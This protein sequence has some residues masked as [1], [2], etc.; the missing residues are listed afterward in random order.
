[1]AKLNQVV[2][3]EK[4][5]KSRVYSEITEI[6][7]AAQKPVLFNGFV[8]TYERKDEDSETYPQEQQ[9]VQMLAGDSLSRV[10]TL[11]TEMFDVTATKDYGN[12][13]AVADIA[14]DGQVLVNAVPVPFLLFLEKQLNDIRT[15]VENLPVLDEADEWS[16]DDATGLFKTKPVATH[17]TKKVQKPIVLYNATP[18][19]PAQTQLITEDVVA[20][21]WNTIKHSGAIPKPRQR[22]LLDR[23]EKFTNAVK[24]AREAANMTD[25]DKVS[26]GKPI[27][28]FLFAG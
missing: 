19:H 7:K 14:V 13:K 20:G 12:M 18:E 15:F 22:E 1:M 6:H 21:Y 10:A 11:L 17:R 2:A 25:A 24:M 8:K 5:V 3:I 16:K 4:G 27:F 9:K 23:I 26:V 28:D